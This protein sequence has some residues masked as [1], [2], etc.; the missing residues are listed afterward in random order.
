MLPIS[1]PLSLS[2]I[3]PSKLL[4]NVTLVIYIRGLTGNCTQP[5]SIWGPNFLLGSISHSVII[6]FCKRFIKKKNT[7]NS[8]ILWFPNWKDTLPNRGY[9][10]RYILKPLYLLRVSFH[11]STG[12]LSS[13]SLSSR[14]IGLKTWSTKSIWYCKEI[15]VL[16]LPQ[17][18]SFAQG[19]SY[20]C[21]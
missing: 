6:H 14:L 1:F 5:V 8:F 21:S 7:T 16:D 19:R 17:N 9:I 13:V 12:H 4:S 18:I 11:Q 20:T 2:V 10:Q 15:A 3:S